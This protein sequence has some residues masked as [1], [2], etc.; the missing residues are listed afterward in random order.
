MDTLLRE[1]EESATS[2]GGRKE[3]VRDPR[4]PLGQDRRAQ[5]AARSPEP[6]FLQHRRQLRA[7]SHALEYKYRKFP[8]INACINFNASSRGSR[9][10]AFCKT[11]RKHFG[12]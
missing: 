11:R 6:A 4:Q 9:H 10:F 5:S 12:L 2:D 1:E 8:L 7:T 3:S